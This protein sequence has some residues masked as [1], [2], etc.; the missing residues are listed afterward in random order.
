MLAQ[1]RAIDTAQAP[2]GALI[3]VG[4]RIGR[5]EEVDPRPSQIDAAYPAALGRGEQLLV[6]TATEELHPVDLVPG[7]HSAQRTRPQAGSSLL[8]N[9]RRQRPGT[10]LP[11]G[12]ADKEAGVGFLSGPRRREAVRGRHQAL[13]PLRATQQ[14]NAPPSTPEAA[15]AAVRDVRG[16]ARVDGKLASSC[17]RRGQWHQLAC[18]LR[19]L[20]DERAAM[21]VGSGAEAEQPCGCRESAAL[22]V[23][24][25]RRAVGER[26]FV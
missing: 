15:R 2:A 14:Q 10:R 22:A 17:V 5:S 20:R 25:F 18:R 9:P 23:S 7:I 26:L 12:V 1:H 4:Q 19:R 6:R 24:D 21:T 13:G 8:H 11:V 3:L 16:I